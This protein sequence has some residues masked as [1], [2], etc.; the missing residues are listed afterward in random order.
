MLVH[1][2]VAMRSRWIYLAGVEGADGE[3]ALV[4]LDVDEL[5]PDEGVLPLDGVVLVDGVLLLVSVEGVALPDA[6]GMLLVSLEEGRVEL[7]VD[8]DVAESVADEPAPDDELPDA[9]S[10]PLTPVD[11]LEL[12][13][14]AALVCASRL[15][16]E[17]SPCADWN[18]RSAAWVFDPSLP[19]MAP[20]S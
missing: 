11:E 10:E 20:G 6:D 15:P 18:W 1:P 12:P 17:P 19:S 16:E 2:A 9:P 14:S 4:L 5:L 8:G 3:E 13:L 7:E